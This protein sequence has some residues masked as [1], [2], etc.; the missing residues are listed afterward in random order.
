MRVDDFCS[1]FEEAYFKT[2]PGMVLESRNNQ[3]S[4][5][6]ETWN[7]AV[8]AGDQ[9]QVWPSLASSRGG[10]GTRTVGLAERLAVPDW[11]LLV[12]LCHSVF[13]GREDQCVWG[14]DS[15]MGRPAGRNRFICGAWEQA[16]QIG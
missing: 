10:C 1:G 6:K 3:C 8:W 13:P 2:Y 15:S 9:N 14:G 11:A 12:A 4:G 16:G 5:G 7:G